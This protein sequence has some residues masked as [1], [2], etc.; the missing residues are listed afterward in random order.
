MGPFMSVHVILA[1]G[2]IFAVPME[3]VEVTSSDNML[4][5]RDRVAC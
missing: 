2:L 5:I 4:G 3:T 1:S